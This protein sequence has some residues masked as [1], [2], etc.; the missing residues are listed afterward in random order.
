VS[1]EPNNIHIGFFARI[2]RDALCTL[3]D[4]SG[5]PQP[6]ALEQQVQTVVE[7]GETDAPISAQLNTVAKPSVPTLDTVTTAPQD[8][9]LP[10]ASPRASRPDKTINT[11]SKPS[12]FADQQ[13]AV[14][15][16]FVVQSADKTGANF[17]RTHRA[18]AQQQSVKKMPL[19]VTARAASTS[20][21]HQPAPNVQRAESAPAPVETRIATAPAD[22]TFPAAIIRK[23]EST[24]VETARADSKRLRLQDA[25]PV[26]AESAPVLAAHHTVERK[27]PPPALRI[28][29]VTIRV[30]D[31]APEQAVSSRASKPVANSIAVDPIASAESR[32]FLRTL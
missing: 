19:A 16:T 22:E 31:V 29:S 21:D 32:H 18:I 6:L 1:S 7:Y 14:S 5:E 20:K 25:P 30:V 12:S 8:S 26:M 17:P 4:T 9:F 11:K 23:P 27:T 13:S 15:E 24:N 2:I 10:E 3:P 28:G